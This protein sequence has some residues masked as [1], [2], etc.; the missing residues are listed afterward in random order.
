M[1]STPKNKVE[2]TDFPFLFMA[3]IGCLI[4]AIVSCAGRLSQ[5]RDALRDL[6]SPAATAPTDAPKPPK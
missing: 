5:I 1:D 6:K 3:L 2:V 4:G